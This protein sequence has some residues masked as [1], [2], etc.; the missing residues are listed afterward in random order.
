MPYFAMSWR[1]KSDGLFGLGKMNNIKHN[2]IERIAMSL[3]LFYIHK[4]KKENI[5]ILVYEF[6]CI[7]QE[8][9]SPKD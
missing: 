1:S 4:K 7:L 6:L 8:I 5:H 9:K 3:Y 2:V